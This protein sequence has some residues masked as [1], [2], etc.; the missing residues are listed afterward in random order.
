MEPRVSKWAGAACLAVAAFALARQ[1]IAPIGMY[2]EGH[3]LTDA[4]LVLHGAVPYRDF[5]TNYPPAIFWSVALVWK[6]CGVSIL[7]ERLMGVALH[8]VTAFFAGRIAGRLADTRTS[9]FTCGV[10][11]LWS[12]HQPIWPTAFGGGLA[13]LLVAIDLAVRAHNSGKPRDWTFVGSA[14]GLAGC[15]RHDLFVYAA[16]IT[17]LALLIVRFT[18]RGD[19]MRL[20]SGRART[21]FALALIAPLVLVWGWVIVKAGIDAPL[22]DLAIDQALYMAPARRLPFPSFAHVKAAQVALVLELAGPLSILGAWKAWRCG[23]AGL[24]LLCASLAVLPQM[25][26]RSDAQHIHAALVPALIAFSAAGR[27][28][29][30][31]V[32]SSANKVFVAMVSVVVSVVVLVV[33]ALGGLHFAPDPAWVRVG[34]ARW[35]IAR[36]ANADLARAREHVVDFVARHTRPDQGIFVGCRQHERVDID[37]MELYFLADRPGATRRMQFEAGITERDDVQASMIAEL[38]ARATPVVVLSDLWPVDA[39]APAGSKRLDEYLRS[40]YVPAE[41]DGPYEIRLRRP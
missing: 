11:L 8:L 19:I 41:T 31:R 18:G 17:V 1:M 16:A 33:G 32:T 5:Y 37:E 28:A 9:W 15:F 22:H 13:L 21:A 7:S 25:L 3:L 39:R 26:S 35:G 36:E 40:R 29:L 23:A 10:V 24:L 34:R 12:A 30:E 27:L 4:N 20:P 2:D 6:A 38:E 14:L